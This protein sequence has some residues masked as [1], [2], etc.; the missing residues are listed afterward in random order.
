MP[1][2]TTDY[3]GVQQA[4]AIQRYHAH[5]DRLGRARSLEATARQWIPRYA[6][7]WHKHFSSRRPSSAAG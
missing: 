3:Y 6:A 7:L 1:A 5:L 4:A 2:S